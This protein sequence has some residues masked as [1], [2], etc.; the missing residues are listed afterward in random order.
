MAPVR[1]SREAFAA[2]GMASPSYQLAWC[3]SPQAIWVAQTPI[4][5]SSRFSSSTLVTC[6]LQEQ[7]PRVKGGRGAVEASDTAAP[8]DRDESGL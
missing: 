6:K 5:P 1:T 2:S 7:T 8:S 4:S 3:G